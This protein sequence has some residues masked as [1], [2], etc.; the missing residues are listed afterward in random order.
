MTQT[1][2]FPARQKRFATNGRFVAEGRDIGTF[3][4]SLRA[5]IHRWFKYPAGYSYKLV[6]E[7]LKAFDIRPGNWILDPFSGSGTTLVEAKKAGINSIG[8]EAHFFVHWAAETKLFWEFNLGEL[9][10]SIQRDL[11]SIKQLLEQGLPTSVDLSTIFPPLVHKCY[12]PEVLAQ[13]YLFR[14]YIAHDVEPGPYQNL[15]KLALTDILRTVSSA[16]TGWPYIAPNKRKQ[17][18]YDVFTAYKD[19]LW[20][21]YQDLAT[22]IGLGTECKTLN[23]LGDTR[24]RLKTADGEDLI[25]DAMIDLAITSP[26]YLNNYDY[27]DRTRLELY[28]FGLATTWREI[29]ERVRDELMIAATTQIRRRE[30]DPDHPLR[31]AIND[32]APALYEELTEKI[33]LLS[34]RRLK[35]GGR[36]DYDFMVAG[37]FNDMYQTLIETARVLKAGGIYLL[38]L[39]DS[40]PYGVYIPTDEYLGRLACAVG[41]EEYRI[42]E[43]RKRGG[44]WKKNPQRHKVPLR[45]ALLIL[46]K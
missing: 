39:G 5:P 12:S 17:T 18:Q 40:A 42:E 46:R 15:L 9:H 21:M 3:K 36:K 24:E 19:Q 33:R 28:F 26:P 4:D 1:V 37:Y 35:K 6:C 13:L 27:A 38:V 45:E 7:T 16:G 30:F 25:P 23:I 2:R 32:C 41:F 34:E 44:K 8:I 31:D 11:H 22:T 43:L 20:L 10:A 29:T 14:E